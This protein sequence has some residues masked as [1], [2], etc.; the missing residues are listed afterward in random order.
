M[1]KLRIANERGDI[2]LI[3]VA[4]ALPLLLLV[5][6]AAFDILRFPIL[7][8]RI[9]SELSASSENMA[10]NTVDVDFPAVATGRSW[11]A[12]LD[13]NHPHYG[14]ESC[15]GA[16]Y[17]DCNF[18]ADVTA[19]NTILR[20]S[21]LL[22]LISRITANGFSL[23]Q[24]IDPSQLRIRVGIFNLL[25]TAAD[26]TGQIR[27]IGKVAE[28]DSADLGANLAVSPLPNLADLVDKHFGISEGLAPALGHAIGTADAESYP[29]FTHAP[30]VVF[31]CY[32]KVKHFFKF[33]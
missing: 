33:A 7:K 21:V 11:C 19:T 13:P 20:N 8:Q 14:C 25:T 6:T 3:T 27:S 17:A 9:L 28:Q 2:N 15:D 29:R 32:L 4:V 10:Q 30:V 16:D 24:A 23:T 31:D 26:Q 1:S 22:P 5:A 12:L 18:P